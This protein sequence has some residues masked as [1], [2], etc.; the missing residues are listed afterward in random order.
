MGPKAVARRTDWLGYGEGTPK[1]HC[2]VVGV[3]FEDEHYSN[4]LRRE[5]SAESREYY[6][7]PPENGHA[8]YEIYRALLKL[9][10]RG[11]DSA[12]IATF[13]SYGGHEINMEL[14]KGLVSGFSEKEARSRGKGPLERL[15]GSMGI[16]HVRYCTSASAG[17][18]DAQPIIFQIDGWQMAVAFN[19]TIVDAD[20][21]RSSLREDHKFHSRV[22]TEVLGAFIAAHLKRGKDLEY[23]L[24]EVARQFEGGYS[25]VVLTSRGSGELAALRDPHGIRPLAVGLSTSNGGVMLASETVAFHSTEFEFFK[26]VAPGEMVMVD[27][28]APIK[29]TQKVLNAQKPAHCQFELIYFSLPPSLVDKPSTAPPAYGSEGF[30]SMYSVRFAAGQ[31]MALRYGTPQMRDGQADWVVVPVPESARPAAEGIAAGLGIRTGGALTKNTFIHRTF[32][33]PTPEERKRAVDMKFYVI[34]DAFQGK[35]VILV[36]DSIVRGTTINVPISLLRKAGVSRVEVWITEPPIIGYCPYGIDMRTS[37]ELIATHM[38]TEQIRNVIGA[39]RL[40]Y[41]TMDGLHDALGLA[42]ELCEGCLTGKYP[43]PGAQQTSDALARRSAS[44]Q[45][46]L[47]SKPNGRVM[48]RL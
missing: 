1:D 21:H 36:D 42:G 41:Q 6:M 16:G 2:G 4:R 3:A 45:I 34:P 47:R 38:D 22:D 25:L 12:G 17:M 28:T 15:G 9:Q 14:V 33:L 27:G 46:S 10:H 30:R 20:A 44:A 24:A 19:G 23:A 8:S 35:S 31:N 7:F 37:K 13:D 48:A 26:M 39:D 43:T 5:R 18:R 11:Q 29:F 32:T 40:C